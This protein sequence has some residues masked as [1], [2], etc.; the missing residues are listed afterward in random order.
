MIGIKTKVKIVKNKVAPPFR[1][2][3]LEIGF[4]KGLSYEGDLIDLGVSLGIVEKS[5]TWY[6]YNGERMGQGRESAKKYLIEH[7]DIAKKIDQAIDQKVDA[8]KKEKESQTQKKDDSK[9]K[10]VVKK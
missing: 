10:E 7:I 4:G 1:F 5:G 2:A 9:A 6:S 3:E 8:D